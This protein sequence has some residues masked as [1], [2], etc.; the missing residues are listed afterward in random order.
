LEPPELA[1]NMDR[2]L[3]VFF[4]PQ[5]GQ[6]EAVSLDDTSSSNVFAQSRHLYSNI[7]IATS[8]RRIGT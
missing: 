8:H 6:G 5:C 7:G 4:E 1:A 2:S 3:V